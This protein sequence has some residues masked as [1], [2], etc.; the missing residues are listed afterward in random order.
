MKNIFTA[1][2][3]FGIRTLIGKRKGGMSRKCPP[4]TLLKI[5]Y[6]QAMNL[7]SDQYNCNQ[8]KYYFSILLI[9]LQLPMQS[10]PITTKVVSSNPKIFDCCKYVFHFNSKL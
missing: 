1:I 5:K 8:N 3:Y 10:A 6:Y 2:K 4:Y 7:I 9:D